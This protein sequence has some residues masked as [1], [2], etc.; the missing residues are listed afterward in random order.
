[1]FSVSHCPRAHREG[2]QGH[3]VASPAPGTGIWDP[4]RECREQRED[5]GRAGAP[6]AASPA[7]LCPPKGL[8]LGFLSWLWLFLPRLSYFCASR[9]SPGWG[10]LE[11]S[12]S[13]DSL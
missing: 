11:I 1:M 10:G 2:G 7:Q 9:V 13:A 8:R 6:F 12:D 3:P 4:G 5:P